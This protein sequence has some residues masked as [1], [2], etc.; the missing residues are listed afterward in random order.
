MSRTL[1]LRAAAL[2]LAALVALVVLGACSSSDGGK[3]DVAKQDRAVEQANKAATQYEKKIK[4]ALRRKWRAQALD[5]ARRARA[6][7]R[8]RA[9]NLGRQTRVVVRPQG[10]IDPTGTGDI[11]GPIRKRFPGRAGRADRQA[12]ALLRMQALDYL[13]LRCPR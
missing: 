6:H 5:R 9:A 12:R 13:N 3:A 11:C 4:A 1:P 8:R 2:V 7:A 10:T